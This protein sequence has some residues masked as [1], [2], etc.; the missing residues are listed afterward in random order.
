MTTLTLKIHEKMAAELS[1][2]ARREHRSKSAVVREALQNYLRRKKPVADRC[3]Y[4]LAE[5]F[6]GCV[7]DG[8][9]DLSYG[10]NHL[11]GFGRD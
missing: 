5:P 7:K 3:C 4:D 9:P 1:V 10:K 8:D 2:E 11:S 6:A